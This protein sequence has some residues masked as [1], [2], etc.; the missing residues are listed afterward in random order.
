MT[1]LVGKSIGQNDPQRAIRQTHTTLM[2]CGV[3]MAALSLVFVLFRRELIGIFDANP[4]V[5]AVGA[6]LMICAAAFQVFDAMGIIYTSALRGAGDTAWPA[7]LFVIS[8]WVILIGGGGAVALMAPELGSLGPWMAA[9]ILLIFCGLML[10]WR[11]R[12]RAWM[13]IDLFKHDKPAKEA[14]EPPAA[15]EPPRRGS[16]VVANG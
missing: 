10:R 9:T 11:W 15:N 14:P 12:A 13:R 8:H 16:E 5:I 3:Y 7:L 1:S 4:E 2:I 6:G